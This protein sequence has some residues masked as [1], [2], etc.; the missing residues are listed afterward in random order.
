MARKK[1]DPL[2]KQPAPEKTEQQAPQ[3]AAAPALE[4][5]APQVEEKAPKKAEAKAET[6]EK[7]GEGPR[8]G[9]E[10]GPGEKSPRQREGRRKT[11][12]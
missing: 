11:R 3:K 5:K 2:K 1:A 10:K 8:P 6:P 4:E 12:P 9:N 7:R